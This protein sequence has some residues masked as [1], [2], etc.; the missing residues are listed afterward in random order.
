[1]KS[2]RILVCCGCCIA[3]M[4]FVIGCSEGAGDPE[5]PTEPTAAPPAVEF[6]EDKNS[7]TSPPL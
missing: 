1:M 4:S 3:A 2:I 5:P 7:D 6:D